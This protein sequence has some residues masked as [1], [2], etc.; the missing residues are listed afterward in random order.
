MAVAQRLLDRFQPEPF[1]EMSVGCENCHGPGAEHVA[2]RQTPQSQHGSDPIVNPAKLDHSKREAVCNQCHLQTAVRLTRHGRSDVDFRPGQELEEIWTMLDT[3]NQVGKDGPSSAVSHVQQMRASRCYQ[4]SD[5]RMG[6]TSCHDPHRL[7]SESEQAAFY[8]ERCLS[9]HT[10]SSC[11]A[12]LDQRQAAADSC[13]MCHMPRQKTANIAHLTQSDHRVIRKAEES[14]KAKADAAVDDETLA[15]F[16]GA[17]LRLGE[18][19]RDRALGVGAWLHLSKKGRPRPLELAQFL[20]G[21]IQK[22]PPDGEMLTVLGAM[23]LD[24]NRLDLARSYEDQ[25]KDLPGP[26]RRH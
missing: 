15:F 5:G 3:G 16:D 17:H 21:A 24:A 9:C 12:P 26:R 6:C 1:H 14:Q 25:A 4:E 2:F 23:A 10:D 20:D 8:R 7:P 13:I 19:E 11:S 18:W 22:G